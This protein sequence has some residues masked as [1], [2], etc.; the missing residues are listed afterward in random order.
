MM[1]PID[2]NIVIKH[3]TYFSITFGCFAFVLWQSVQCIE[4]YIEKPQGTRLSLQHASKI[5]QFPAITICPAILS[6][7]YDADHLI[8]CGLRYDNNYSLL[9]VT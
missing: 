5:H 4:K 2:V 9:L 3:L 8:K 1:H 6:N 7:T